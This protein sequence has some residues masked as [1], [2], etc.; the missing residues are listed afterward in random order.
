MTPTR[1]NA[2]VQPTLTM[3][4][5]ALLVAAAASC[6]APSKTEPTQAPA[7]SRDYRTY[8]QTDPASRA[9]SEITA[10]DDTATQLPA[11]TIAGAWDGELSLPSQAMQIVVELVDRDG[12]L[13]GD[14]DIP[15]QLAANI[16]LHDVRFET[17]ALHFEMLSGLQVAVFDGELQPDGSIQG[18]FMQSG[19]TGD[20][21]L[22]RSPEAVATEAVPYRQEEI[23]F[24]N[25][26]VTLAGTLTLPAGDGPF[27]AVI[28]ISGSGQQNRD[29]EISLVPGYKPFRVIADALMRQGIAVLRY[30]DR[31]VGQSTG[32]PS[33]ATTMDF[34]ADAEAGIDALLARPEIAP[35]QIG[36]LGHSEGGSIAAMLAARNPNV[37]FVIGM[38]PPAVSGYDLLVKQIERVALASGLS[39][40]QAAQA[41]EQERQMLDFA[42]DQDWQ[43]AQDY[44]KQIMMDQIKALPEDQRAALGDLEALAAQR[45]PPQ[46]EALKTPWIQATLTYDVGQDWAKITVPVLA[47][48]G[49][50]DAQVDVD[51]NRSALE[52]ALGQ[53]KNP[54]VTVKVF[55]EANHLFLQAKT[56]SP[57]EYATLPAD[58][59]PGFVE[60]ISDWLLA[61][62][63]AGD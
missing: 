8:R 45:I 22:T 51:Q 61:R 5:L 23:T 36:V 20:F 46:I 24:E 13:A 56:G 30:D 54:D 52:A 41:A 2:F 27:P 29:E 47:L 44:L 18:T 21:S 16:P 19:Y 1:R 3:F 7:P 26:D 28:L 55:P 11:E 53:A 58:F 38:A 9:Y 42:L 15:A 14:I 62:V 39:A 12:T 60:T 31:G 49:G 17:P 57:N 32:D 6:A 10:A 50:L 4:L 63:T 59:G 40:D 25:G 34:A 43:G 37:A 35:E 48:F 33:Q